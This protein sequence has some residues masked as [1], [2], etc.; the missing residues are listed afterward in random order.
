MFVFKLFDKRNDFS[1]FLVRMPYI[2]SNFPIL[3]F[4]STLVGELL[5]IGR[6]SLLYK[7]FDEKLK[8]MLNRIKAQ[9]PQLL[10]CKNSF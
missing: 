6:I 2:N 9:E 4:Y 5:I 7:D 3:L 10:R 8:E 1:F